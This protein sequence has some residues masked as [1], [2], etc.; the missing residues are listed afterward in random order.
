M[1]LHASD[2]CMAIALLWTLLAGMLCWGMPR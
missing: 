1:R 2:I